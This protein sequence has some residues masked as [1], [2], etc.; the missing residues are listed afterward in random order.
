MKIKLLLSIAL[1]VSVISV[2]QSKS[3]IEQLA[4]AP[5]KTKAFDISYSIL[6]PTPEI[7]KWDDDYNSFLKYVSP[8][9]QKIQF[10][11]SYTNNG[12]STWTCIPSAIPHAQLDTATMITDKD[13]LPGTWRSVTHRSIRFV[14][15]ACQPAKKIYR[16]DTL[17]EDMS[18]D[19]VFAV[20][21]DNHFK[22]FAK[23]DG[24][25][26]F[27]N[28]ISSKYQLENGRYLM[29]YKLFKASSGISQIG[30]DKDGYLII[31]YAA[32]IENKQQ[33]SYITYIAVINQ[34]IF[35]RVK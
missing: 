34:F 18:K 29:L 15:S 10:G 5:K 13:K 22:L 19:D 6:L 31:N 32:V 11:L 30:I 17:L 20:F 35:E 7:G 1:L 16:T 33:N 8:A 24:K 26:K 9:I 12:V 27:K 4:Q 21:A 2:G 14:D 28:I 23:E 3:D 25:E